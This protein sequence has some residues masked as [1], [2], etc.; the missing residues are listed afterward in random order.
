MYKVLLVDDER[1]IL[2]GIS[3]IID[4][5]AQ[6]V[7]LS[8]TARNGI[9][10]LE[11]IAEE[12]P[13]I[14]ITDITM[15]G[16]DGIQLIENC[17]IVF[18]EI[19]WILLSGYNEFEYAR[20]AMRFGVKHYLL[21]PCNEN[22]ISSAIREV[23][24]ELEEQEEQELYFKNVEKKVNQ[25]LQ[26]EREHFFKEALTN[27]ALTEEKRQELRHLIGLSGENECYRL[28]LFYPEGKLSGSELQAIE[29]IAQ[30]VI[31]RKTFRAETVVGKY[32]IILLKEEEGAE[33]LCSALEKIQSLYRESGDGKE[34][35]IV[36]SK[37]FVPAEMYSFYHDVLTMLDQ[38]FYAGEGCL[39]TPVNRTVFANDDSEL[40]KYD[41]ERLILLLKAGKEKE[42]E[43]ELQTIFEQVAALNMKPSLTKSYFSQ[44]YL[45]VVKKSVF[46][47]SEARLRDMAKMENM[48]TLQAFRAFFEEV[49][50]DC[51][52]ASSRAVKTKYSTVVLKMIDIVEGSLETPDL[53][54]Q[55]VA[56]EQLYMNA[57]YLGKLFKKETG[58]KFSAYVTNRRIDKAVEII[59]QEG[60]IKVFELAERLGFGDNPQYFSQIFKRV[61]GCTPSDIIKF[62]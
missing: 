59:E 55:W 23:V 21:K 49:F 24:K 1:T 45:S 47:S 16:M 61:K 26:E 32:Y 48:E 14:V 43:R 7:A 2:E 52:L 11:F 19:K 25:L 18:P 5:E 39:I 28:L 51:R 34:V 46:Y 29:T 53:S 41:S 8:G 13:D 42:I 6:G 56:S 31:G 9:E 38:R 60:D 20:K 3:A 27:G 58:W 15:P 50:R 44:L 22:N 12:L 57:D 4:W 36:L 54:L 40:Y 37:A 62:S 33:H 17:K 10:A 35:T 30:A